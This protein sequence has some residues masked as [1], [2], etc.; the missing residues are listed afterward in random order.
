MRANLPRW[1]I[2]AQGS[3]TALPPSS[4]SSRQT[5]QDR[6]VSS[7]RSCAAICARATTPRQQQVNASIQAKYV[8]KVEHHVFRKS[9][10]NN[11]NKKQHQK[12]KK[13]KKRRENTRW[14]RSGFTA[15]RHCALSR[16]NT[17]TG[18]GQYKTHPGWG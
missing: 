8:H 11:N 12:A 16:P 3:F 13:K 4:W 17:K 10:K 2:C 14:S 5:L 15:L 1:K 6:L 7:A 9:E 18:D